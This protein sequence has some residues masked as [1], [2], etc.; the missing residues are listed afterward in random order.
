MTIEK[1]LQ[2]SELLSLSAIERAG[3]LP[4]GS[5]KNVKKDGLSLKHAPKVKEVLNR[6]A[7]KILEAR[8]IEDEKE[9]YRSLKLDDNPKVGEIGTDEK[10]FKFTFYV[11]PDGWVGRQYFDPDSGEML[12]PGK[13]PEK[14]TPSPKQIN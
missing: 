10:G 13:R 2:E 6:L 11:R 5:I 9:G 14:K 7:I 3:G 1:L 8:A 4:N 12:E